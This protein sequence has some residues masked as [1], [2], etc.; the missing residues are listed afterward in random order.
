MPS[1]IGRLVFAARGFELLLRCAPLPVFQGEEDVGGL[2]QRF[3]RRV[4]KDRFGPGQPGVD[5]AIS[6]GRE[7]RIV[8]SAL[9][10]QA[11]LLFAVAQRLFESA[12]LDQVRGLSREHV[13]T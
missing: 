4:S 12:P 10:D 7:D 11:Q 13:Q 6:I 5:D 3:V 8:P 1:D 2:P 9:D